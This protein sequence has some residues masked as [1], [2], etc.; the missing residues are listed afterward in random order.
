M[1][2]LVGRINALPSAQSEQRWIPCSEQ[3]PKKSGRYFVTRELKACGK[4]WNRVYIINY[5]EL[6]G[7][8]SEK[9][10]W[11]GNASKL[12]FEQINDVIAWMPLMKPYTE[13]EEE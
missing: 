13:R 10:W 1:S 11:D 7:L 4:L 8:K 2:D 5:S 3:T 6:P 12:G 9:V